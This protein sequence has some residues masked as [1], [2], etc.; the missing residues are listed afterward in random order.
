[1]RKNR[2]VSRIILVKDYSSNASRFT[3]LETP[4]IRV[5]GFVCTYVYI[6]VCMHISAWM[7]VCVHVYALALSRCAPDDRK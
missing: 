3:K 5:G 1:M 4:P 7:C 2:L 6:C